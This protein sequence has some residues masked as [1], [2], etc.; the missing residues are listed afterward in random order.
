MREPERHTRHRGNPA[1]RLRGSGEPS[2]IGT[3]ELPDMLRTYGRQS[4]RT[5]GATVF[6]ALAGLTAGLIPLALFSVMH[7]ERPPSDLLYLA[8]AIIAGGV[9][10]WLT[11]RD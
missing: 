11:R 2:R 9:V 7:Q 10:G 6:L 5:A 3:Q 8:S 1:P 4:L